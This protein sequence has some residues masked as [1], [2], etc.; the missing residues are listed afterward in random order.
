MPMLDRKKALAIIA[1]SAISLN[2]SFADLDTTNNTQETKV[3]LS[4]LDFE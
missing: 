4:E 3:S 1:L 2:A